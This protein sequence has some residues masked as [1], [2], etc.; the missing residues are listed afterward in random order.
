VCVYCRIKWTKWMPETI[1]RPPLHQYALIELWK[2]ERGELQGTQEEF[3][4]KYQAALD[5]VTKES[6]LYETPSGIPCSAKDCWE[7]GM[8]REMSSRIIGH[9]CTY[10]LRQHRGDMDYKG[11]FT[12]EDKTPLGL[13]FKEQ[14]AGMTEN[15][16]RIPTIRGL[17]PFATDPNASF[18]CKGMWLRTGEWEDCDQV[19]KWALMLYDGMSWCLEHALE[20]GLP[21]GLLPVYN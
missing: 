2:R 12:S 5:A 11:H 14:G 7:P 4:E 20:Q 17:G 16:W 10:H 3:D 8:W 9:F 15:F 13:Y 6:P 19:A 21:R 18:P 1:E